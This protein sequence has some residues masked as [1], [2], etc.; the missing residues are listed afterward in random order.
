M[1]EKKEIMDDAPAIQDF[2]G[3]T[4]GNIESDMQGASRAPSKE[5]TES[6]GQGVLEEMTTND[7]SPVIDFKTLTWW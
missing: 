6:A 5:D 7:S 3:M 4:D 2:G 1:G